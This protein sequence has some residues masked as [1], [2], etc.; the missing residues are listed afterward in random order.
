[1]PTADDEAGEERPVYRARLH[2]IVF[3]P[4]LALFMAGLVA[5][6]FQPITA[7]VLLLAS[8]AAIVGAYVRYATTT[9]VITDR[10]VVYRSGFVARK[11]MEMRKDKIES[12]DVSQ[13]VLGRLLD[14]GAVAVKGTGGGIEAIQNVAAPFELRR[15]VAA[16]GEER[17][18][19]PE[20]EEDMNLL[21]YR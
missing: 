13:S 1:M 3:A 19:L 8:V 4:P 18:F 10:R 15:H 20:I 17:P 2:W 6:A 21:G 5:A 12:I 14:F 7:I 16:H 11:T 9:I